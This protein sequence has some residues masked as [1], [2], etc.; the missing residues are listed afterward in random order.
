MEAS[1]EALAWLTSEANHHRMTDEEYERQALE[2]QDRIAAMSDKEL[3]DAYNATDGTP[4]DPY[5]EALVS[6][7]QERNVDI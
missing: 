2:L 4:G 5:V 6:A 1:G 3:A 7:L